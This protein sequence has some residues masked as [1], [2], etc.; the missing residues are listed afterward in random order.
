MSERKI[1]VGIVGLGRAG[2]H[3]HAPELALYPGMFEIVAGCDWDPERR[4]NLPEEFSRAR[5]YASFDEL[6]ADPEVE[7][8]TVATRNADHTPQAIA[9]LEAGKYAVVDKPIAVSYPQVLELK[10]AAL[11]HPGKLFL[12]FNRRFE[13]LFNHVR[14]I[15][16]S[17]ILG[18]VGMVKVYRHPGFVRRLDWQTLSKFKGGMLSNWGPH[19]IDQA[20]QFLEAPVADLWSDL[21]HRVTA[22]DAD[23]QVK[24]LL[25]GAN[26]R[27]VDLEVSTTATLPVSLY[28]VWGDRGSLVAL[29][30]EK[31]I[32][33]RYLDPAQKLGPLQAVE[34]NFGL[35]YGN[36]NET[37][38]F[39]EEEIP[40]KGSEGHILQR[41]RTL[42]PGEA[43]D[44]SQGYTSPDAMWIHIYHNI[45]KGTPYPVTIDEG[46]EVVRISELAR[47]RSNYHPHPLA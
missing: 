20:L 29:P 43:P 33:L 44:P 42:D 27:V 40:V 26:G 16:K 18:N 21:Q 22:G 7:M 41:G 39:I 24:I 38:Q 4:V 17:G 5:I 37:L 31:T 30:D 15:M 34:G 13:P 28:E 19:F 25:R 45:T 8:V 3:M 1:K 46:V 10:E 32:R 11:R 12:R 9:A 14:E 47:E 2:R 36:P 6:L 35:A 23:D